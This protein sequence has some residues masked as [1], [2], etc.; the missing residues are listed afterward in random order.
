MKTV[1]SKHI[2]V[3]RFCSRLPVQQAL[4]GLLEDPT[5]NFSLLEEFTGEDNEQT[6]GSDLEPTEVNAKAYVFQEFADQFLHQQLTA[7][8]NGC[9]CRE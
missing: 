8:S 9:C 7:A 6:H 3:S 2:F 4:R 5:V 1:L